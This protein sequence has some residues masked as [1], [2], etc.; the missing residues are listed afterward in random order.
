MIRGTTPTMRFCLPF[1]AD[2]LDAAYVTIVQDGKTVIEKTLEECEADENMLSFRLT[3][4]DTLKFEEGQWVEIQMRARMK[5][6]EA[7]ASQIERTT[8]QRILKE[9]VI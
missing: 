5:S 9:G 1:N 8:V 2:L 3:Q 4:D 7:L 6:G